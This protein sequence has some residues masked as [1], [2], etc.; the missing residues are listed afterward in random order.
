MQPGP[1]VLKH[2]LPQHPNGR[3]GGR[4][5]GFAS[6]RAKPPCLCTGEGASYKEDDHPEGSETEMA[7]ENPTAPTL[8]PDGVFISASL[9]SYAELG[10]ML[11]HIPSGSDVAVPSVKMFEAAEMLVS[12]I[13]GMAQQQQAEASLSAARDDNEALRMELVEAKSREESADASLLEAEDEMA[14]LRGEVR[15]LRMEVSIEKKQREDLQ[16][17]LLVQKE[18]LEA[19][20]AAEKGGT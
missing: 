15:Q 6:L 4:K 12:G 14:L 8:V 18:E 10:E 13:R 7:E 9:F 3:N 16:L 1:L 19:E 20:F 5:S 2:C 17:C 11:K